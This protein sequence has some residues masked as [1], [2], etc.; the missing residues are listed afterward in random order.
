MAKAKVV[1]FS[2][3]NPIAVSCGPLFMCCDSTCV[4]YLS[5]RYNYNSVHVFPLSSTYHSQFSESLQSQALCVSPA[6]SYCT[7]I[8]PL[9][10]FTLQLFALILLLVALIL[11]AVGAGLSSWAQFETQRN[12]PDVVRQGLNNGRTFKTQV[13]RRW[14]EQGGER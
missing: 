3:F 12:F 2:N 13:W 6:T 5:T 7:C 8:C 14:G 4:Q 10:P 11:A 1:S 9:F